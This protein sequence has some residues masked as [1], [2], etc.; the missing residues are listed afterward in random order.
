M[1]KKRQHHHPVACYTRTQLHA[2]N[3]LGHWWSQEVVSSVA[4]RS[5]AERLFV[6]GGYCRLAF[7]DQPLPVDARS[8]LQQRVGE[9]KRDCNDGRR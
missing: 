7:V 4:Y 6:W 8:S 1:G 3:G 9:I 2:L 5:V